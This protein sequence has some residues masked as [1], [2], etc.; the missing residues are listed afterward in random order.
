MYSV[1]SFGEMIADR[2]RMDAYAR[3]LRQAIRP[4]SI[5]VDIGTGTGVLALI[6]CQCGAGR[7]Y[8]IDTSDAVAVAREAV[9]DNG[10][11]DRVVIIH[12]RSTDVAIPDRADVIVSDI[13]G[14]LP[15]L[16]LNLASLI[17]ARERFLANGGN[18]IP[19]R[20]RIYAALVEFPERHQKMV[21]PWTE[22]S[23]GLNLRSG[24]RYVQNCWGKARVPLN[25]LLSAPRMWAELDYASMTTTG[26]RGSGELFAARKGVAHGLLAWFDTE[27]GPG[28][29]FSNAPG[30]PELI[31]GQAFFPW[32]EA[33]PVRESDVVA[34]DIR[35]DFVGGDYVWTWNSEVRHGSNDGTVDARFRQSSFIGSPL[36]EDS[37]ARR[38]PRHQP[39]LSKDGAIVR[40][41]LERMSAGASLGEIARVLHKNYPAR[42]RSWQDALDFASD[43]SSRYGC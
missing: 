29:G 31:Y 23:L 24:L 27:L 12:Q 16:G 20:D 18:L 5:V 7:V 40:A 34:F 9:R 42:F 39:G 33:V 8:A 35:A 2:V 15:P 36:A 3:A 43:I 26:I 22:E 30:G 28:V 11:A 1:A 10:F 21:A 6:S 38:S 17:D 19:W 4:G 25:Q 32:P 41:V 37:F 13:R 14:V